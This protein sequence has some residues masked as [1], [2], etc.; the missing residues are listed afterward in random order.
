[1]RASVSRSS[2][3]FQEYSPAY[4]TKSNASTGTKKPQD[5]PDKYVAAF[6]GSDIETNPPATNDAVQ[7]NGKTYA[8][9]VDVLPSKEILAEIDAK[10]DMQQM[11]DVLME[12]GIEKFASPQKTLLA[13]IAEKRAVLAA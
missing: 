4:P 12:E 3:S 7:T 6:A 8:R 1:M 2:A 10:I 13:L 9:Q 11:E 5:A